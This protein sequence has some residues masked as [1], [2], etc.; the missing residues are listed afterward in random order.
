MFLCTSALTA[1]IPGA[2]AVLRPTLPNCP[3]GT[4][5]F[6][7]SVQLLRK[8]ARL[9]HPLGL[10]LSRFEPTPVAIGR[11]YPLCVSEL[12]RPPVLMFSGI[13]VCRVTTPPTCQ[14]PTTAFA[15][16]LLTFS[17]FPLPTGNSY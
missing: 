6:T 3:D 16:E 17:S 11:S 8:A 13:P 10:G 15:T 4:H 5:P 9:Y 2:T 12:S 14:P 1:K 7:T